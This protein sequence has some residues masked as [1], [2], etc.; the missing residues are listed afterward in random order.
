MLNSSS[1][2][3]FFSNKNNNSR[4]KRAIKTSTE[5]QSW[6]GHPCLLRGEKKKQTYDVLHVLCGVK[7]TSQGELKIHQLKVSANAGWQQSD[8]AEH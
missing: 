4:E 1:D 5:H 2:F 3:F 7:C 8:T 6:W